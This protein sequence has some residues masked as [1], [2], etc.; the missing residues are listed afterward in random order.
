MRS[1]QPNLY[2][3]LISDTEEQPFDEIINNDLNRTYPDNIYFTDTS[4]GML[5]SLFNILRACACY[6]PAVG[7]CQV[8]STIS[9]ISTRNS[10]T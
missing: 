2:R 9:T 4:D 6:N 1:L 10:R 8:L 3:D 5:S 7:Y